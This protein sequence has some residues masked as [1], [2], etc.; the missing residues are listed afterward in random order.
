MIVGVGIQQYVYSEIRVS[1]LVPQSSETQSRFDSHT[2]RCGDCGGLRTN[3]KYFLMERL[4]QILW[5]I[6]RTFGLVGTEVGAFITVKSMKL[7]INKSAKSLTLPL[8]Y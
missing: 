5:A 8:S 7:Q 3:I 4:M 2:F 6:S 1:R